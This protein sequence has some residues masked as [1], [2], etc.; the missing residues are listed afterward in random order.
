[1]KALVFDF[2]IPKLLLCQALSGVTDSVV[3]GALSGLRLA[4]VP[5]PALPGDDWVRLDVIMCGIC[6][7]DLAGLTFKTSPVLEPFLS[8]PAVLG[9]EILARVIEVGPAVRQF[10]PGDRVVVDP[11]ISCVVRG[12]AVEHRCPSCA[13]GLPTTCAHGGHAGGPSPSGAP[14]ARGMMLGA[15]TDLPGGFGERMVAHESQ[16]HRVTDELSD[17]AAV[18]IE[19]LSIGVHAVLQTA[20]DPL[21]SVLVIGSGP[22]ALG[23]L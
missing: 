18:L 4:E 2:S 17:G 14:L 13:S 20:L 6:G 23:N 10:A 1:M 5:D 22:I 16:L 7:S 11:A 3:Y 8:M 9:H 21:A 19:P 12:R 15:H